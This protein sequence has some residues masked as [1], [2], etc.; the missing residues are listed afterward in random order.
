MLSRWPDPIWYKKHAGGLFTAVT[1]E[2]QSLEG[3]GVTPLP[4]RLSH[5][6]VRTRS[7]QWVREDAT[8][9]TTLA[10]SPD[11]TQ[12]PVSIL[13][14]R[15]DSRP[16]FCGDGW[17]R[18][19]H[20]VPREALESELPREQLL[21]RSIAL[22]PRRRTPWRHCWPGQGPSLPAYFKGAPA[23]GSDFWGPAGGASRPWSRPSAAAISVSM[24]LSWRR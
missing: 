1:P 13:V 19:L 16:G 24:R 6:D 12:A 2:R 14:G 10:S 18:P 9:F 17:L 23:D 7:L 21:A 4:E 20:L 15:D 8:A 3:M 22:A 11:D 5:W